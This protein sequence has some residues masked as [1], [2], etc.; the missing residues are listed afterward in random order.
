MALMLRETVNEPQQLEDSQLG[1]SVTN[2]LQG[3]MS[4]SI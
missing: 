2:P 1:S 4:Y 3:A